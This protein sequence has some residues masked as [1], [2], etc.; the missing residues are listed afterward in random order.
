MRSALPIFI[1]H[2]GREPE[3]TAVCESSLSRNSSEPLFIQRLHEPALRHCGFYSRQW[4]HVDGQRF[5]GLDGTP[6]STAFSFTR[7]LV[8]SLMQHRGLAA[9]CDGDFLFLSDP[10]EL[11]AQ[12]DGRSAVQVAKHRHNT[13]N[14]APLK[15]D[16]VV[17]SPYFRKN[18]SSLVLWNCDHP[19]NQR[20][21]PQIVNS[22]PGQWLHAF[23]WLSDE[24]IG[25]LPLAW[26][27]LSGISPQTEN[28]KAVH[29]TRGIPTMQG[30]ENDPYADLWREELAMVQRAP[31]RL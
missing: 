9:F 24:E 10:V 30:R 1:G 25:D 13:D 14:E 23:S 29:F 28:P 20:I 8:P 17:Q 22:Q 21:I 27:W 19:S 11:F 31:N 5:D 26:N 18:W 7:F 16:G 12:F 15:M 2:D 6:F 4:R 3:A